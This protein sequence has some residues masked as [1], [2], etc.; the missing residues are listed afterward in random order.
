MTIGSLLRKVNK[1]DRNQPVPAKVSDLTMHQK[2]K[3]SF[4]HTTKDIYIY[5]LSLNLH[6]TLIQ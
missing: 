6:Y 5:H 2:L 4:D 1:P 3:L